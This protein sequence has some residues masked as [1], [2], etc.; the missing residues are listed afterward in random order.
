MARVP[1]PR[2]P[3][4][5][6]DSSSTR[7]SPR[8][9][10]ATATAWS[11]PSS[12]STTPARCSWSAGWTTRRCTARS[13][14]GR[15]T[16]WSPQPAGVLAQGR[17]VRP[18][19]VGQG[20]ARSTA[21]ATRCSSRS[22]RSGAACHTGDRTCFDGRALP[23]REGHRDGWRTTVP[24]PTASPETTA[25][26]GAADRPRAPHDRGSARQAARHRRRPTCATASPGRRCRRSRSWRATGGS[27]RSCAGCWP[28]PRRPSGSTASSPR[29]SPGTF[30]LESAE[31]GGVWSRYSIVG[32]AQPRHPDRAGR[33]GPLDRRAP[34]RRAH[35]RRPDRGPAR[36]RRRARDR[37]ALPGLP[38]LTGGMVGA[39]TYDAV[40]RWEK[41]PDGDAGR[42]RTCP[43][44]R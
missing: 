16:F 20:G 5:V 17:H 25:P 12:S 39:I 3:T 7:R 32:A 41:V 18:R 4:A 23:A 28:T 14:A 40:R 26:E 11:A 6:T 37:R 9:S 43:S 44:S 21:T 1:R 33:R 27:S 8:R 10:S 34:G 22:T 24:E 29:T 30:L 38:P 15:V 35:R 19:P 13:P 2:T 42:A 31:H 36:H